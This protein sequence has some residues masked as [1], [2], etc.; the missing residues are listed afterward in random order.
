MCP[1]PFLQSCGKNSGLQDLYGLTSYET[2]IVKKNSN[3][4]S[5]ERK[6]SNLKEDVGGQKKY[7]IGDLTQ[8]GPLTYII[9]AN[10]IIVKNLEGIGM[11]MNQERNVGQTLVDT[12]DS[13]SFSVK[14][15]RELLRYRENNNNLQKNYG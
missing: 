5:M 10:F 1:K 13:E 9:F 6:I 4:C 14:S 11:F 15:A 8:L 7:R 3:H 2:S 12:I